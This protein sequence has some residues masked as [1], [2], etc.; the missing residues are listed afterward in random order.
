ML[1]VLPPYVVGV[2]VWAVEPVRPVDDTFRLGTVFQEVVVSSLIDGLNLIAAKGERFDCPVAVFD[3]EDLGGEGG[4]DAKIVTGTLHRPPEVCALIKCCHSPISKD[5]IHGDKLVRDQTMVALQ[6]AM[7]A[8]E[9]R[10]EN[11]N[12]LT[13][14]SHCLLKSAPAVFGGILEVSRLACL[15]SLGPELVHHG[16][17]H[18]PTPDHHGLS[19]FCD[20]DATE[21]THVDLDAMVHLAQGG[22]RSM[23]PTVCKEG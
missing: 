17:G 19:I 23:C 22:E 9:G 5:D 6:P 4:D 7:S 11:A 8:S 14:S 10:S 2:R 16:F 21:L 13:R 12:T 18:G 3:V 15:L 1:V 20:F